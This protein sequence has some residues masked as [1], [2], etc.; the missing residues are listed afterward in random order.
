MPLAILELNDQSLLIQAEDG[1]LYAEPGFA[2]LTAQGIETGESAHATAWL[3]P[4]HNYNQ[5][6]CQLNQT[7]LPA[8]Q[9]WARHHADIAFA[10]LGHLWRSAGSPGSLV[11]LAPG[12]F[13]DA[14]LSLLLGMVDALPCKAV[15]VIDS[16]L[17]ACFQISRETMYID[18]QLH[19]TVLSLCR[20]EGNTLSIVEQEVDSDLGM[21][22]IFNS[23]AQYISDQLIKNYRHDP[24][25][26]SDS[27]QAIYDQLPDWLMRLR[28]EDKV[29]ATLH[30][31]QGELP[32]I[33]RRED[34][35]N[36]LEKRLSGLHSVISRH[37]GCQLVLSHVSNQLSGL[38]EE[39]SNADIA[40]QSTGAGNVLSHHSLIL[41]Q[42]K[43]QYRL[44]SLNRREA[45]PGDMN[46]TGRLATHVL[47]RDRALPLH[48]PVSIRISDQDIELSNKL[49]NEAELIVVLRNRSLEA[50]QSV[51]G[52]DTSLPPT[53]QP[54][55]VIIV[56]GHQLTL[57]EV[58]DG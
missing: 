7:P 9:K 25:H 15:A 10:Q 12:S 52:I 14:Q 21:M 29:S 40:E 48:K 11:V 49:D 5:H 45:E 54:G 6:W 17:A 30:S 43:S 28:F 57:I 32:F 46:T 27:E 37:P 20:L 23:V 34:V 51:P 50:V 18:L 55:E 38:S 3:E 33:L 26:N 39:I 22:Q 24:L 19:Q 56:D 58:R 16:A 36:L 4:Q 31:S 47:Y 35:R 2:R 42:I 41:D 44:R 13:S 1:L 8:K 53:C